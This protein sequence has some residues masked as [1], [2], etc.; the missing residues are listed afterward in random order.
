MSWFHV[1][2]E[3]FKTS[4]ENKLPTFLKYHPETHFD[5]HK[6]KKKDVKNHP[7]N[8]QKSLPVPR[9]CSPTGKG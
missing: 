2:T 5:W 4:T 1:L 7:K 9:D 6:I 8:I 3:Q